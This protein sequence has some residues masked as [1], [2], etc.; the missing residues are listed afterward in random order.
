ML[1][2][3]EEGEKYHSA[4]VL[5]ACDVLFLL[6]PSKLS[7]EQPAI[8]A[9]KAAAVAVGHLQHHWKAPSLNKII[10]WITKAHSTDVSAKADPLMSALGA[11][12][13]V[14]QWYF[15]ISFFTIG[16]K[17][18]KCWNPQKPTKMLKSQMWSISNAHIQWRW[19][20]KI[21]SNLEIVILLDSPLG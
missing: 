9:T 14:E 2:Q 15:K 6:S 10:K 8:T 13:I 4:V 18:C 16:Q 1:K 3:W 19:Q 7:L 12:K 11:F 20:S 21:N 5:V 17:K